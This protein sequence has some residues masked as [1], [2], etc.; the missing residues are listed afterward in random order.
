M[1]RCGLLV[2]VALVGLMVVGVL[3]HSQTISESR[4]QV[5]QGVAPVVL[6]GEN[7]GFRMTAR[8]GDK[9]VGTLVVKLDGEWREVEFAYGTR[10]TSGQ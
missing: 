1:L 5:Q 4:S 8:R 3:G 9:A 2:S 6:A 10:P 7:I